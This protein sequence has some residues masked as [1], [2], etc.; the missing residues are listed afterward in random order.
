MAQRAWQ[1]SR[2]APS[3]ARRRPSIR[4]PPD[5]GFAPA[6]LRGWALVRICLL[7]CLA[8]PCRPILGKPFRRRTPSGVPIVE[9]TRNG[10]QDTDAR[11]D[12]DR[13]EGPQGLVG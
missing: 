7:V 5:F 9:E 10:P 6:P 1:Q 11:R 2:P 3:P 13:A 4:A 8:A 12:R